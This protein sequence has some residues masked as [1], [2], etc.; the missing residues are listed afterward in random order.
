MQIERRTLMLEEHELLKATE[1]FFLQSN[2][3]LEF[4]KD[5]HRAFLEDNAEQ[6]RKIVKIVCSNF[7]C[8]GETLGVS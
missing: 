5:A 3:L 2:S 8:D 7:S 4:C 1:V 6:E